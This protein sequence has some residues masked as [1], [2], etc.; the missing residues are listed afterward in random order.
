MQRN[1]AK[2]QEK[3]AKKRESANRR[4]QIIKGNYSGPT[5]SSAPAKTN[6]NPP[7]QRRPPPIPVPKANYIEENIDMIKNKENFYHRYPAKKYENLFSKRKDLVNGGQKAKQ[8][9]NFEH[10][11]E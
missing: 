8:N 2:V 1:N 10:K 11:Q 4:E 7:V 9:N 6:N 5:Q 3:N